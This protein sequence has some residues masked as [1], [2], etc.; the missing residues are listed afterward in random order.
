MEKTFILI[1][2]DG[3]N[4]Q[5]IVPILQRFTATGLKITRLEMVKPSP[6]QASRHYEGLREKGADIKAR[7]EKT[8]CSGQVVIALLEGRNAVAKTRQVLGATEPLVAA[9]GTIRGDWAN[10][11]IQAAT[12]ET[13]GMENL[14]HASDSQENAVIE[15]AIWFG[16]L[17]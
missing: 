7:N 4:R 17:P 16:K 5:L 2:P 14:A 8:L 9:P 12:E 3:V 6:E 11:T 10:D 13:R 1:K 15:E